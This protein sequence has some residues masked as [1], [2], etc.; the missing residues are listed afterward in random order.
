MGPIATG[1][2]RIA[3]VNLQQI[4]QVAEDF[5]SQTPGVHFYVGQ[6]GPLVWVRAWEVVWEEKD[7]PPQ[8]RQS[9]QLIIVGSGHRYGHGRWVKAQDVR[10][11]CLAAAEQLWEME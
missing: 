8:R 6:D 7:R 10:E 9:E 2:R 4:I 1:N 5:Q 3:K 11:A